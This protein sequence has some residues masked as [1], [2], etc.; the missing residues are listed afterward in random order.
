MPARPNSLQGETFESLTADIPFLPIE[1]RHDH[2]M[3]DSKDLITKVFPMWREEDLSLI[4]CKDGITNKL[5]KCE[6]T[7][8]GTTVLVRAY[9]K[10][11]ELIINRRQELQTMAGLARLGLCPPLYARF[12]NGLV[13]G[14]I[15]GRVVQ[16]VE[17]GYAYISKLIAEKLAKWH[18][19]DLPGDSNPQLFATLSK[20]LN[21]IPETFDS[22]IKQK[23]FTEQFDMAQIRTE[24]E[25]L[26][27]EL[28]KLNSPVV[29]SH[30]DLL[31]A[32]IIYNEA[33]GEIS[34]IDYEYGT[35]NYRGFDIANHF[36][37]Y[38]G[39]ECDYSRYPSKKQQLLWFRI[40]LE[41]YNHIPPTDKDLEALFNEVA[42][43]SL[44]SH[45]YWGLWALVQA[46]ISDIDFDYM[47]YARMRFDKYFETKVAYLSL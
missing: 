44:A 24:L 34:F 38:A 39:F 43:F 15:P 21:D 32:N 35:Y 10:K 41:T 20:W 23:Q 8:S 16:P 6:D 30:N 31:S 11:S 3:S 18:M 12:E 14:F 37:E 26:R 33:K 4:Q 42:K 2:L 27:T 29:F 47:S 13:Y 22:V 28:T 17:M 9:G 7:K 36:C 19:V 45:F 46:S 25:L 1:V 40:Y 5:V